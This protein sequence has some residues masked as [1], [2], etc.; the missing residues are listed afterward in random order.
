M[1]RREAIAAIGAAAAGIVACAKNPTSPSTQSS[2][3]TTGTGAAGTSAATTAGSCAITPEETAG[4]YPDKLGLLSNP[5]FFRSDVTEGKNGLPLTL[6]LT[7][8]SGSACTAL[9]NAVIEIWH[10][11]AAGDY[12][13][14]SQP[15]FD[16]T[17]Q[18]FLRGFQTT[19]ATGAV[20]FRT[21]YPG[22]YSGRATH[23]HVEVF[24]GGKSVKTTQ[25]AFPESV[26]SAVY[27]TGVYAPHGQNPTTNSA[28]MVFSD[29]TSLE[30]ASMAGDA[31]SGYTAALTVVAS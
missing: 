14:Y 19:D 11:D 26:T 8:V 27:T 6:K 7:V 12:S 9:A 29:G 10:C 17:G 4:P 18:T 30:M 5:A 15:G 1:N 2:T 16:G 31:A 20:T 3:G 22:W 21:I 13:E 25:V 24:V 23:I 28:D